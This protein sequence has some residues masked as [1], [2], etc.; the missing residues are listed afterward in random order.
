MNFVVVDADE[1]MDK[2]LSEEK[3]ERKNTNIEHKKMFAKMFMKKIGVSD[4][5]CSD[6]DIHESR[7]YYIVRFDISAEIKFYLDIRFIV[8]PRFLDWNC[9]IALYSK[10]IGYYID[11]GNTNIRGDQNILNGKSKYI[12]DYFM[13]EGRN[14]IK[15]IIRDLYPLIF[16]TDYI[17]NLPKAYTFLLCC[18]GIIP[19]GVDKII[20]K[21]ILF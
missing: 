5:Q 4:V 10:E 3:R 17:Q 7:G 19:K 20:A 12:F 15:P 2:K 14:K 9:S 21:K 11:F 13:N 18:P 8:I 16:A 1:E 6:F